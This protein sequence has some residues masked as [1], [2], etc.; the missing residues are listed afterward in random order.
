[1]IIAAIRLYSWIEEDS[2]VVLICFLFIVL[3][4]LA[5]GPGPLLL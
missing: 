4:D 5:C 1:M 2:R 3:N